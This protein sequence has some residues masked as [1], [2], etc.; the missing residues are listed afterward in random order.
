V[1][2]KRKHRGPHPADDK[3][4]GASSLP[5]LRT[6]TA[7]LSWLL[8]RGYS[9]VS[10]L[11]LVGDR[12][13]LR[14]RQRIAV[15]RCA[16]GESARESR[17][18]RCTSVAGFAGRGLAIDGFNCLIT[19]EAAFAGGVVLVGRD[20][21]H[22]DLASVHGSYRRVEETR[23]ALTAI[24]EVLVSSAP[25]TVSWYLDRPVSNSGRLRS[26]I[27]EQAA[28]RGLEWNV[29]LV[30]NPD[31]ALVAERDSVVA[32]CDSWVLDHCA[33]WVDLQGAVVDSVIPEA[34]LVDLG[35]GA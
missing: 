26:L 15:Q 1:P 24:C 23:R 10:A 20:G 25:S 12:H 31:R 9:S 21:C 28:T 29:E 16:C 35:A 5:A 4:F 13:E 7:E 32:S 6:A 14:E 8:E 34:W 30:D 33:A 3:L 22:R 2:D 17:A 27:L 11:K 18:A 19:L